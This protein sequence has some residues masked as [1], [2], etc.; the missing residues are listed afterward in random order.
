[1]TPGQHGSTG[2][3]T[4]DKK[5]LFGVCDCCG[6]EFLPCPHNFTEEYVDREDAFDFAG[7]D[8]EEWKGFGDALFTNPETRAEIM[9]ET[10][11]TESQYEELVKTGRVITGYVMICEKCLGLCSGENTEWD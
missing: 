4:P 9:E 10:G 6:G 2:D 11:I 3:P 1:M 8:G 5:L 7:E